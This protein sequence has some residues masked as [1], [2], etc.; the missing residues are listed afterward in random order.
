MKMGALEICLSVY[1]VLNCGIEI[2]TCIAY[3]HYVPT[4]V[5]NRL[6]E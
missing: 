2:H 5:E 6:T 4:S 3:I 1:S